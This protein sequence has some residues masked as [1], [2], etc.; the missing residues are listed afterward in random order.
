MDLK[1]FL[2]HVLCGRTLGV[3]HDAHIHKTNISPA[4][5]MHLLGAAPSSNTPQIL[6]SLPCWH[7]YRPWITHSHLVHSCTFEWC[8]SNLIFS[9]VQLQMTSQN[10]IKNA[11][12]TQ[13]LFENAGFWTGM[14]LWGYKFYSQCRRSLRPYNPSP[15]PHWHDPILCG[16][17]K[18]YPID[19]WLLSNNSFTYNI[20][21]LANQFLNFS[22]SVANVNLPIKLLP[23]LYKIFSKM[24]T[25]TG[26]MHML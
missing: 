22:I 15:C 4:I 7:I 19:F 16:S 17:N 9:W 3:I 5:K 21:L 2:Q 8:F 1:L 10:R 25:C 18:Y 23:V 6:L 13:R 26:K 12:L 14:M 20:V 11:T 24:L